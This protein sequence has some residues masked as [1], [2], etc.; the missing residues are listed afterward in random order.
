MLGWWRAEITGG[1]AGQQQHSVRGSDSKFTR[2]SNWE[3]VFS[4]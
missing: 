1:D 4:I 2:L 3:V